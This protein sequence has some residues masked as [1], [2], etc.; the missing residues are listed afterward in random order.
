MIRCLAIALLAASTALAS[1]VQRGAAS[2]YGEEHRGRPMADGRPFN[3][4]A[5]TCASWYF[6][7]GTVLHV[8]HA[9][10]SVYVVVTDRGPQRDLVRAGRVVD[11]SRRAFELLG[12]LN[13]GLLPVEIC[14][15]L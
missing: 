11:L 12:N 8:R 5:L 4:D 14:P 2:W 15:A 13:H 7:L 9:R 3:P 10:R 6:P 1:P